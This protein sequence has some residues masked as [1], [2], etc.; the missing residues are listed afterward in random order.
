MNADVNLPIEE[1]IKYLTI[2]PA[3]ILRLDNLTGSI[4]VGKDADFNVFTLE[5]DETYTALNEKFM[6]YATY[7]KGKKLV[8][9][10]NVR[11]TL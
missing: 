7:S 5:K 1:L 9:A 6:P 3:K 2:Y 11:F 8:K 10:G 4:A